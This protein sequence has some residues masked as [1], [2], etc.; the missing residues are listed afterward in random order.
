M[1]Q[2]ESKGVRLNPVTVDD[3]LKK[4][5]GGKGWEF[6]QRATDVQLGFE[7]WVLGEDQVCLRFLHPQRLPQLLKEVQNATL[8]RRAFSSYIRAYST[9]PAEEKRFFHPKSLH[10]GHLAKAFALREAPSALSSATPKAKPA[11]TSTTNKKRKRPSA[12]ANGDDDDD[13]EGHGGKETTARNE[14]ERRMYAA[15]RKAGKQVRSQG[16]MG[17]FGGGGA[18]SEFQVMGSGDLER[19]VSDK[20]R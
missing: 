16:K 13:E 4:G 15:V 12:T 20:R 18:G 10:L 9:H 6:E 3:V 8:A 5:F 14:T 2:A 1:G 19:M 11:T 17:Q 7:R